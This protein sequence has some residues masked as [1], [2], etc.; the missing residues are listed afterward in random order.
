M[1]DGAV[2]FPH[3]PTADRLDDLHVA[4]LLTHQG[5]DFGGALIRHAAHAIGKVVEEATGL[6]V[7]AEERLDLCE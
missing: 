1:I 4:D 3:A 2:D 6:M 7:G 5:R